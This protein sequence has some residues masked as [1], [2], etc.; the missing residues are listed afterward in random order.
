MNFTVVTPTGDRPEAFAMCEQYMARQSLQPAL[1]VVLDDGEVPTPHTKGQLYVRCREF[2]GVDSLTRKIEHAL[3]SVPLA[4][5]AVA[6]IED[7]DWYHPE[8]LERMAS[9]LG[10]HALVGEG[11]AIYYNV[12]YRWWW[13]HPNMKHASLCQTVFTR[14]MFPLVVQQSR[15]ERGTRNS[16]YL[17]VRLWR[18]AV[19]KKVYD[20]LV[21]GSLVVGIKSMPGRAGYGNGHRPLRPPQAKDD[22]DLS[23]LRALIGPDA[24]FYAKHAQ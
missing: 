14:E 1:W 10:H 20:P 19:S 9:H 5:D 21:G 3:T 13:Q 11:K 6:I 24:D 15:M 23:H 2:A 16:P 8:Y 4:G 12:R 18:E 7:D 22:H 17:D